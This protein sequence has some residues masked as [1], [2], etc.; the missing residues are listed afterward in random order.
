[1]KKKINSLLQYA[2]FLGLAIFLVW[3]SLSKI[4]DQHWEEMKT[5]MRETNYWLL[6][7]VAIALLVSHLS[8]AI[9]WRILMEPMGFKPSLL[10]TYLAV[11]IGYFAN[12]GVPRLGEVLKCTILSRYEK[13]PADKLIG[14]IVAER[15]F[16]LV[17]LLLVFAIT[18]FSQLSTIGPYVRDMIN[19]LL[20]GGAEQAGNKGLYIGLGIMLLLLLLGW[21]LA[22]KY[23]NSGLVKKTGLVLQGIW[24]GINSIR[25]LK[26]RGWF[27]FHSFLIWFLYL[28]S[29]RIGFYAMEPTSMYGWLPSFSVLSLGSVGMIV[30]PGGMG[31]YPI[32]VQE[33]MSLYGLSEGIGNAFGYILW[34]AQFLLI[35]VA[36]AASLLL[37]P[38]LNRKKT[39]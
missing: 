14:T 16:D 37:L 25:H 30:T 17:C 21:W 34:L 9:R 24:Q 11:L 8:R 29:I 15:A 27:L 32:L 7:P 39:T 36:G 5:A 10:N 35:L 23:A 22:K 26:N 33:T 18:F 3:W 2:F 31:A 1:M 13:V 20:Y 6:I 19:K 28:A 12:Q 4:S 38:M